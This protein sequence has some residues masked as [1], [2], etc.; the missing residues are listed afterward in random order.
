MEISKEKLELSKKKPKTVNRSSFLFLVEHCVVLYWNL[1][2][3][4]Y[5]L[6]GRHHWEGYK[7][8]SCAKILTSCQ[9]WASPKPPKKESK[10]V[11][12]MESQ[13][14]VYVV[15]GSSWME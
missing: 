1:E 3:A 8:I 6:D 10:T 14:R 15:E 7:E 12:G 9:A 2:S 5:V 4:I 13:R 11:I